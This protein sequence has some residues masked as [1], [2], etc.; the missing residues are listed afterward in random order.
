MSKMISTCITIICIATL[1]INLAACNIRE[2]AELGS[3]IV[4][5]DDLDSRLFSLDGIIYTLPV[6]FSELESNGWSP[7]DPDSLFASDI[8]EPGDSAYWGLVNA[9]Q[10]IL[11]V[12][13]NPSEEVLPISECYIISVIVL[14]SEGN[15]VQFNAELILPGNIMIGSTLDDVIAAYGDTATWVTRFEEASTLRITYTADY[16][17]LDISV[18][19][20]RGMVIFMSLR[21]IGLL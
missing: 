5:S 15:P 16:I 10:N 11:V 8:L 19:T 21:Y 20:E 6:S 14:V 7:Y 18:D 1:C 9:T 13:E 12:L 2:P 4:L 3:N 17:S